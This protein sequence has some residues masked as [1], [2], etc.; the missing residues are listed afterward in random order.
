MNP[1]EAAVAGEGHE[2]SPLRALGDVGHDGVHIGQ[3]GGAFAGRVQILRQVKDFLSA[4]DF[5]GFY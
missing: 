2:F 1:A 4:F 3:A 5:G